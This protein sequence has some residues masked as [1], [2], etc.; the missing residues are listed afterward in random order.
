VSSPSFAVS[1]HLYH[2]E[3]LSRDHLVEIAAH[4]FDAVE[5]FANRPHLTYE[6]E[7]AI[8]D[9]E[10]GL[11]DAGLR[12]HSIHAPIADAVANGR[13]TGA[14]SIASADEATRSRAV[15]EIQTALAV[16]RRIPTSYL[17]VHMG[18]PDSQEPGEGDNRADAARRSIEALHAAAEP[19]GVRLALE[20]IPNRLSSP[21]RLVSFIEDDLDA[22]GIGICFDSGHAH[23]MGDIV[24]AVE[25]ISGHLVT[26]H[27]HDNGGRSDDHLLP[28][29]GSIPWDP[30]LMALQKI[31]FEGAYVFELAASAAPRQVLERARRARQRFESLL[32]A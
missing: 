32:Q 8:V 22:G 16:A 24:D 25:T 10:Q 1:T 2:D 14:Y 28:F 7:R 29:D 31:G 19:L 18:I 5:L 3:R 21:D 15:G 6:D 13:W 20:V 27:V 9:L 26:T 11:S 4:G 12:L 23:L 30:T 17:V